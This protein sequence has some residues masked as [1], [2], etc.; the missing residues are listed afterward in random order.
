VHGVIFNA[1]GLILS[2]IATLVVSILLYAYYTSPARKWLRRLW[3][4]KR[5]PVVAA[6]I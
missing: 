2:T 4:D 1:I 6:K 5:Q 3:R